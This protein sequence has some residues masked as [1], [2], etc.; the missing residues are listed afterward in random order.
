[1]FRKG[2]YIVCLR[3]INTS[4]VYIRRGW[5]YK[6]HEDDDCLI[7]TKD[8][9]NLSVTQTLDTKF[10]KK[11]TWRYA[12]PEEIEMYDL[13]DEPYP[14]LNPGYK[15]QITTKNR[16]IKYDTVKEVFPEKRIFSTEGGLKI[17][18]NSIREVLSIKEITNYH[19]Y[20]IY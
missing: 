14:I 9:D 11:S 13:Y 8:S 5:V 3:P 12:A 1:M 16:G 6:Q 15:I 2:D 19:S 4:S 20:D 18:Y 17:D 10:S 7:A